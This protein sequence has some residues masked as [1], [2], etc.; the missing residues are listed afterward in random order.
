MHSLVREATNKLGNDVGL[1]VCK[2]YIDVIVRLVAEISQQAL[3]P[4]LYKPLDIEYCQRCFRLRW[5]NNVVYSERY[6]CS[7]GYR[8]TCVRVCGGCIKNMARKTI[9]HA[10]G[11]SYYIHHNICSY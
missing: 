7:K 8:E 4:L 10:I 5:T 9:I 11:T 3:I 1:L 6:I 2:L